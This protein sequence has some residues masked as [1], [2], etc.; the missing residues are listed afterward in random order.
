MQQGGKYA[1]SM[2]QG[3]KARLQDGL[4]RALGAGAEE[5][6]VVAG[7]RGTRTKLKEVY[8]VSSDRTSPN[9]RTE[10]TDHHNLFLC[11]PQSD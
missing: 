9:R 4:E 3:Y 11:G 8:E 1:L 5:P 10:Q 2:C 7:L 6:E